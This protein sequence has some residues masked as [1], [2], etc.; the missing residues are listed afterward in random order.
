MDLLIRTSG[1]TRLSDFMLWGISG[2]AVLCFQE[3]LWPDF[4]FT[5]M[6]Y[7]VWTYQ[8]SAEH[9][10]GGRARYEAARADAEA[11]RRDRRSVEAERA[12]RANGGGTIGERRA[13]ATTARRRAVPKGSVGSAGAGKTSA[14]ESIG[15]SVAEVSVARSVSSS[16]S[17]G[18]ADRFVAERNRA[19]VRETLETAATVA[20][21]T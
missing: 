17:G 10:R 3:V 20:V 7:A 2:H 13:T 18:G 12:A 9:S 8:R 19:F 1:E 6:C 21:T 11:E 5:D 14:S 15:T 16:E 4:S